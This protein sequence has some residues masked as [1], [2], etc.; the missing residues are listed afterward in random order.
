VSPLIAHEEW[1]RRGRAVDRLRSPPRRAGWASR[2]SAGGEYGIGIGAGHEKTATDRSRFVTRPDA[3]RDGPLSAR[4]G[5]AGALSDGPDHVINIRKRFALAGHFLAIDRNGEFPLRTIHDIH[6]Q[7]GFF[8][9][10]GRHTGGML[11]DR[12]SLRALTNH[13]V[14]HNESPCDSR[15]R[16]AANRKDSVQI[17]RRSALTS[18]V[19]S[20]GYCD[21]GR[22]VW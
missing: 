22:T 18:S 21:S 4:S 16:R 8:P 10:L 14:P 6:V 20:P 2:L 1:Q 12:S 19:P 3:G 11:S 7:I 17:A 15:P 9:Q 13:C 5:C